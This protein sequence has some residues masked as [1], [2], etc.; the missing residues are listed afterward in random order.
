VISKILR[1]T[2]PLSLDIDQLKKLIR[3]QVLTGGFVTKLTVAVALTIIDEI[4]YYLLRNLVA[5]TVPQQLSLQV[6]NMLKLL[7]Q[8]LGL[9]NVTNDL[10]LEA[11][12]LSNI[13]NIRNTKTYKYDNK[14]FENLSVS[15][16][17]KHVS[18]VI[19][20]GVAMTY[21]FEASSIVSDF[22]GVSGTLNNIRLI[23]LIGKYKEYID[24][25]TK[26]NKVNEIQ[27]SKILSIVGTKLKDSVI[28][29]FKLI[30]SDKLRYLLRFILEVLL[31]PL[32]TVYLIRGSNNL[33]SAI[34]KA[35]FELN[36]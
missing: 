10:I 36:L 33:G 14:S 26:D 2:D 16:K 21:A 11:F 3:D 13:T 32:V 12:Y 20:H 31:G 35:G 6:V 30:R 1:I 5:K 8:H 28:R 18:E 24:K 34:N 15:D 23:V 4:Q 27:G 9:T 22:I 19:G 17:L 7:A 25:S 29:I